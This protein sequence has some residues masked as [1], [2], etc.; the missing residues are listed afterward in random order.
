MNRIVRTV[1][2]PMFLLFNLSIVNSFLFSVKM[3]TKQDQNVLY[4]VVNCQRKTNQH[5]IN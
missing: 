2:G 3:Q 1:Y 5:Y 4:E